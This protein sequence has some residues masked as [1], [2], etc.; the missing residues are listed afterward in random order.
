MANYGK[1][2]I[3]IPCGKKKIWSKSQLC[4]SIKAEDAYISNYFK[5]CKLYAQRFSDKWVIL[6]GKYGIIE[7]TFIL[8]DYDMKLKA[9]EEFKIKVRKQLTPIISDGFTQIISLCGNYYSRFLR[10]VLMPF[11]LTVESPLQGMKIGERQRQ[12]KICLERNKPLKYGRQKK[13]I[14]PRKTIA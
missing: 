2:L 12:L 13:W 1:T 9:S 3:I 10:N 7:P 11:G 4:G 14:E 5:L 6:S 8:D